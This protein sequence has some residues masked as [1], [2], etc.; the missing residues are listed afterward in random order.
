[1][2]WTIWCILTIGFM[3]FS[4]SALAQELPTS[5]G[6]TA[7][8]YIQALR[9]Q[10]EEAQDKLAQAYMIITRLQKELDRL[11]ARPDEPKPAH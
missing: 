11:K 6:A 4:S 1:M 5:D 3:G 2:R 10:R 8:D 9:Q 7:N